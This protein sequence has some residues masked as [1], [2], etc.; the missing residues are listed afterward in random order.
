MTQII[1]GV[2]PATAGFNATQRTKSYDIHNMSPNEM[3]KL[4]LD[5]FNRGEI[6]LKERLPFAPLDTKRL[7]QISGQDVSIKYYSRVWDDPDRK[8]DMVLE[9]NSI[10]KEQVSDNDNQQNINV[11]QGAL[12]LLKQMEQRLSFDAVLKSTVKQKA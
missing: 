5:M 4:T 1:S 10:L 6:S 7:S 11:T 9:F 2:N 12:S 3:D 8:R